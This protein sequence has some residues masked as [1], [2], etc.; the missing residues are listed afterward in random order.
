MSTE[1]ATV[2]GKEQPPDVGESCYCYMVQAGAMH[3][4]G[5]AQRGC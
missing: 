2:R 5:G 1:A 3:T 4:P